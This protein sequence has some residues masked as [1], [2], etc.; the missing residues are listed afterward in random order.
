MIAFT[1]NLKIDEIINESNWGNALFVHERKYCNKTN[2]NSEELN[3]WRN[4]TGLQDQFVFNK[5][6]E[7]DSLTLEEFKNKISL[8]ETIPPSDYKHTEWFITLK[9]IFQNNDDYTDLE[10]ILKKID[11]SSVPFIEF[12]KPFLQFSL[13][14]TIE[15]LKQIGID[16]KQS[17]NLIVSVLVANIQDI[18]QLSGKTLVFELNKS[19]L[20]KDL[21][22]V[23]SKDRYYDFIEKKITTSED[24]LKFL[25]EY[26]VL[27][28]LICEKVKKTT[29]FILESVRNF[30]ED[31][32]QLN[33]QMGIQTTVI[34][35]IEMLGDTHNNGKN[36]ILYQLENKQ[37]LI[38]KPH[39]VSVDIAFQSLLEWF[40]SK[41]IN[42]PFKTMDII[43]RQS[44]GWVEFIHHEECDTRNQIHSFY[45]RQGQYLALLYMLNAT[46]I[47]YENI[48]AKGEHPIIIDLEA[49]FHNNTL[50]SDTST[51]TYKALAD[52]NNSVMRTSLLPI[53][54]RNVNDIKLD[55]SGLGSQE[56]QVMYAYKF[57]NLWSDE[58]KME[59]SVVPVNKKDNHPYCNGERFNNTEF[60]TKDIVKGFKNT[61]EIVLHKLQEFNKTGGPLDMFKTTVI[62]NIVRD[63]QTYSTILDAGRNPKYL[64]SGLERTKLFENMWRAAYKF[65]VLSKVIDSEIKDL[66]NEDI[67][68]FWSNPESAKIYDP[69]GKVISDFYIED[70]FSRVISNLNNFSDK[71][72]SKQIEHIENALTTVKKVYEL[73]EDDHYKSITPKVHPNA[74]SLYS[75]KDY[76]SEAIKI[77]ETLLKDAIWGDDKKNITWISLGINEYEQIEYKPMELGLYDGL[78][79]VGIF[80]AYLGEET[81]NSDFKDVAK[82]C[83]NSVLQEYLD[84]GQ[85]MVGSSA[86]LGYASIIYA[87]NNFYYLWKDTELLALGNKIIDGLSTQ[88]KNDRM[89]DFLGG[90]AGIIPVVLDY[91]KISGYNKCLELANM[92]GNHLIENSKNMPV[93]IAWLQVNRTKGRPLGGLAHGNSGIA[94]AL[95]KLYAYTNEERYKEAAIKTIKYDNSLLVRS[96]KNW[97]DLRNIENTGE[98]HYPIYWCNGA[99]GIGLSRLYS[100][101]YIN[102]N[103]LK[104]DLTIAIDKTV[105]DGFNKT[106]HSL[107]HGDFGNLDFLLSAAIKRNDTELLDQVY[108]RANMILKEKKSIDS[109]WKCGIPGS[110]KPT[111]N[112]FMG[113]AGIGY[114]ML[115]LH[116]VKLPSVL[117]LE[118]PELSIEEKEKWNRM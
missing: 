79:G 55:I 93:G 70:S 29:L 60:F 45:E 71:D 36:V 82:S 54:I 25:L 105:S 116:N 113:L 44:Y 90:S 72:L 6:L 118:S 38:Y 43:N 51:A 22:G 16:N 81:G 1:K 2:V 47:H 18:L 56:N 33:K 73:T 21:V 23:S 110:D 102:N 115:R 46:D 19:R 69:R 34:K 111:P 53:S 80:Y 7:A 8:S 20:M 95:F 109:P 104:S 100:L 99:P 13:S 5:R 42:K 57:I 98:V 11:V 101:D 24:I 74:L 114:T 76:L 39:Q 35:S 27:A 108:A 50:Y 88:V 58:M 37:K 87:I 68:Y 59:K 31:Y 14:E 66:L 97:V 61:Y 49:L 112:L 64:K 78:I 9:Q 86:F 92:C 4:Q 30:Y 48:I 96:E 3:N 10:N 75:K 17:E 83:F 40:N 52:L 41:E 117:I 85:N 15:S 62:R 26:P 77:G 65:P 103:E 67:P 106:S 91:Y 84:M 89:Y 107:C 12:M 94:Y 28:R 63:T 32:T